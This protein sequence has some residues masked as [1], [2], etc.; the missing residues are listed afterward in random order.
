M[1]AVFVSREV[2]DSLMKGPENQ[3]E[4]FHGFTYSGHPVC[5]AR[6]R[7]AVLD[8]YRDEHLLTRCARL[9]DKWQNAFHQLRG[10]PN[11]VDIRTIGLVAGIEF[12]PLAEAPGSR[13]YDAFVKA[14]EAGLL[15]RITGDVIAL[16][17]PLIIEPE[18]IDTIVS[19]LGD[20]LEILE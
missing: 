8:I 17:P 14:F 9:A 11:V 3:I 5:S 2:H 18:Q 20:V 16:S 1:G 6:R 7:I 13:A 10:L 15:V 4:L 19:I 12:S